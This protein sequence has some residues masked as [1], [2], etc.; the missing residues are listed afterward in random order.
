MYTLSTGEC[1]DFTQYLFQDF[2]FLIF[3]S[4][5]RVHFHSCVLGFFIFI[6]LPSK[7][8]RLN[9]IEIVWRNARRIKFKSDILNIELDFIYFLYS[10]YFVRIKS[11]RC[12]LHFFFRKL[13]FSLSLSFSQVDS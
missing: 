6:F 5:R 10:L 12:K 2:F 7:N 11:S 8:T 3:A 13:H 4:V 9:C 1:S